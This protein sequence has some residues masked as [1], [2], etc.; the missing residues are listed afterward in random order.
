MKTAFSK[1]KPPKADDDTD[2][3]MIDNRFSAG[4]A[5]YGGR[6]FSE[7]GPSSDWSVPRLPDWGLIWLNYRA[8]SAARDAA[9]Q[10]GAESD[11]W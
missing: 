1:A 4:T 6:V 3:T 10:S 11:G 7:R 5:C 2:L 8:P 9:L